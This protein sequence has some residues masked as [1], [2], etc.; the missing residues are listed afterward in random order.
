MKKCPYCAEEI[1]DAAVKCKHCGSNL[2]QTNAN[3]PK[4]QII[5]NPKRGKIRMLWGAGIMFLG[6]IISISSINSPA[7]LT[8][9]VILGLAGLVIVIVGKSEHWYHWE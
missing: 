8:V 5:A 3:N 9:G 4:G 7:G 1:Q 2:T 6:F